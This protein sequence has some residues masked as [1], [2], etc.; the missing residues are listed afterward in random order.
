M[1]MLGGLCAEEDEV[2]LALI[3][4]GKEIA[5]RAKTGRLVL[6]DS[7]RA[8]PGDLHTTS[9]HVSWSVDLRS[10]ADAMWSR[11]RR[12]IRRQVRIA[13]KNELIVD[14]DRTGKLLGDFYD[15]FGLFSHQVG[16][17]LFSSGFLKHIVET[18]P[19]EF[20]V[21]VVYKGKQPIGGY[22]QLLM[23]KTVYGVW[24]GALRE[25]LKLRPVYLAYWELLCDAAEQGYHFLD[26]GRS[27][28]GSGSSEFKGRWGGVSSPFY[29]QAAST[30][31]QQ[32]SGSMTARMQT[33]A[34]L[35]RIMRLWSRLP[36]PLVQYLGPRLRRHV[37]FA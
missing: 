31:N 17:P 34:R 6:Q 37:P 14:V 32:A 13:R 8:W 21:A 20:S 29:Q 12:D 19:D 10:G 9:N 33:D 2:A 36:F 15:V 28:T 35:R 25:H 16:T 3:G 11:L 18:F 27:P 4:R 7:R 30:R 1:T 24:G 23:G 26:M 22:F 5:R